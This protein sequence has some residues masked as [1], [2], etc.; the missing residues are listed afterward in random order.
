MVTHPK[1]QLYYLQWDMWAAL[2]TYVI[3]MQQAWGRYQIHNLH[4]RGTEGSWKR[5]LQGKSC[6]AGIVWSW[7][8]WMSWMILNSFSKFVFW[9]C[10]LSGNGSHMVTGQSP[11][12]QWWSKMLACGFLSCID[13]LLVLLAYQSWSNGA[14]FCGAVG[15][16]V[17]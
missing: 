9:Y 1:P 6:V 2:G 4:D 10:A 13:I 15:K 3:V 12:S 5:Q 16:I 14:C 7:M 17:I 11:F 8:L